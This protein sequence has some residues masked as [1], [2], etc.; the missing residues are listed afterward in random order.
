MRTTVDAV[1]SC[2]DCHESC[3]WCSWYAK[4][5]REVGCGSGRSR[6]RCEWGERLKGTV[7]ATCGGTERVRLVGHYQPALSSEQGK[8]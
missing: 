7:C 6:H 8:V 4:N 2:P 3:G 5:A 1:V